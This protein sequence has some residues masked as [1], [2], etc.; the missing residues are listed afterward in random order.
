MTNRVD[1]VDAARITRAEIRNLACLTQQAESAT[2]LVDMTAV[3]LEKLLECRPDRRR[4]VV[5][6]SG[7]PA[8]WVVVRVDGC[9]G[10]LTVDQCVLESP[11]GPSSRA[12]IARGL[13]DAAGRM[14]KDIA[15]AYGGAVSG[16]T[17][18]VRFEVPC[19]DDLTGAALSA[20][21]ARIVHRWK[22]L[23]AGIID[24]LGRLPKQ[25]ANVEVRRVETE[26]DFAA[27]HRIRNVGYAQLPDDRM[28]TLE[29]W[30]DQLIDEPGSAPDSWLVA[31]LDGEPVGML[32]A[33]L[34]RA[35]LGAVYISHAAT[36]PAAQGSQCNHAL[37]RAA[38]KWGLAQGMTWS[39]YRTVEALGA[40]VGEVDRKG[41][42]TVDY[43]DVWEMR[44][45]P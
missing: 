3:R 42:Q 11:A 1:W 16:E 39:R 40:P 21:G 8:G 13:V 17:V 23:R 38:L 27:H 9:T 25:P 43:L 2:G 26:E 35:E 15:T 7:A 44:L 31:Y 30:R 36:V 41:Y 10:I 37:H 33:S 28:L 22:R 24:A 29:E 19:A 4:Y 18:T 45:K 20:R 6:E 14:A 34:S 5:F 32:A 12:E